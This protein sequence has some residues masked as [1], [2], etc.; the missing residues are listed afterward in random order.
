MPHCEPGTEQLMALVS[1]GDTCQTC[2]SHPHTQGCLVWT[3]PTRNHRMTR[4][5]T[6]GDVWLNQY[7]AKYVQVLTE[8]DVI[9]D[10]LEVLE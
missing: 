5:H 7:N 1:D 10:R 2:V 3:T 9:D 8:L 6:S 4:I